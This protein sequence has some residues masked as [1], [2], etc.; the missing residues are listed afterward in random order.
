MG[1]DDDAAATAVDWAP[2]PPTSSSFLEKP[3]QIQLHTRLIDIRLVRKGLRKLKERPN[4][5]IGLNTKNANQLSAFSFQSRARE[6]F[7]FEFASKLRT[8]IKGA[9]EFLKMERTTDKLINAT[10][11]EILQSGR[12][13]QIQ[14]TSLDFTRQRRNH[15]FLFLPSY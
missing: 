6:L 7:R 3:V 4:F 14:A 9:P 1:V 8:K 10:Y 15:Y 2:P 13:Q 11:R 12:R 5:L